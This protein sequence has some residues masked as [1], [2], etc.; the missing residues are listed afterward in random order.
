MTGGSVERLHLVLI[1]SDFVGL[2]AYKKSPKLFKLSPIADFK[3]VVER[4]TAAISWY[5]LSEIASQFSFHTIIHHI[6]CFSLMPTYP[7]SLILFR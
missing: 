1:D 4:Q 6:P 7:S 2:L 5:L 3:T